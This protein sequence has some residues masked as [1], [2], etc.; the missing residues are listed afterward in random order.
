M[1]ELYDEYVNNAIKDLKNNSSEVY[2]S[3]ATLLVSSLDLQVHNNMAMY[4]K[5]NMDCSKFEEYLE[6]KTESVWF[7][8]MLAKELRATGLLATKEEFIQERLNVTD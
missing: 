3:L 8:E 2:E 1:D 4:K 6:L 7:K 5:N